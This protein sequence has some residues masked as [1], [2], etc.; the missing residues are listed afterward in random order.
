MSAIVEVNLPFGYPATFHCPLCGQNLEEAG[1][2]GELKACPHLMLAFLESEGIVVH[3]ADGVEEAFEQARDNEDE[4]QDP[5]TVV[6]G[7][8]AG[9]VA[10]RVHSGGMA[11]GP[12]WTTMIYAFDFA[13]GSE[14]VHK[15]R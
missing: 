15:T 13:R 14:A 4:S 11:C 2:D 10:F 7:N 3:A 8:E 6:L 5:M 12:V 1:E 9:R